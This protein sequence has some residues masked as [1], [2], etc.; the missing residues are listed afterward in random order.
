MIIIATI[1]KGE[2]LQYRWTWNLLLFHPPLKTRDTK[3]G[4]TWRFSTLF[5]WR[6]A[7]RR[8][9]IRKVCVGKN[10]AFSVCLLVLESS[11]SS[12]NKKTFGVNIDGTTG[13][14]WQLQK[15]KW[16]TCV[17]LN[18]SSSKDCLFEEKKLFCSLK[19][20]HLENWEFLFG[21]SL[22][23]SFTQYFTILM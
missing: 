22:I 23:H 5:W 11:L 10:P 19:R 1:T 3:G 7:K 15:W 20:R 21:R 2:G 6:L 14:K 18:R 12:V 4:G 13:R 16:C 8:R 9:L 17:G